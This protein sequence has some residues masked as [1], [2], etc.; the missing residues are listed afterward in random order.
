MRKLALT[1]LAV[2]FLVFGMTSC[3]PSAG[4]SA[5]EMVTMSNEKD[6]LGYAYGVIIASDFF[7][8]AIDINPDAMADAMKVIGNGEEGMMTEEDAKSYMEAF[9]RKLQRQEELKG[10]E[11]AKVN[12]EAGAKFMA[13]NAQRSEIT[14]TES[15][16]QYEVLKSGNGNT[17]ID[18]DRVT[19]HYT[20]T[21][22]DGT[23]FDSSVDRGKPETFGVRQVIRGWTEA[24]MMMKEGDKYKVYI[25]SDI[26]YGDQGRPSIP[27][28][29]TLIFEMELLEIASK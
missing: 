1:S 29:A 4:D 15:G 14:T 16:L 26:A 19:V 22:L 18:T 13:D 21:L 17:P 3:A 6:S 12:K 27:P 7:R 23:V 25:P 11:E 9:G 8:R 2:Y 20:G 28:G 10:L 24:L 5:D